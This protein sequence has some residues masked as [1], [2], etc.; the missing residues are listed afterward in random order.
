MSIGPHSL[1]SLHDIFI[2]SSL[3]WS[4]PYHHPSTTTAVVTVIIIII[5]IMHLFFRQHNISVYRLIIYDIV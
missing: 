1:L 2:T 5:I 3:L 4:L